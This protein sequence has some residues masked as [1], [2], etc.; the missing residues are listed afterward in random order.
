MEEIV[1]FAVTDN[2]RSTAVMKRIGM[3]HDPARDFDHP[4]IPDTHPQ[5][6]RHVPYA[7]IADKWRRQ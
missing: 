7:V 4:R 1:S 5:L 3:A 6:K 2:H